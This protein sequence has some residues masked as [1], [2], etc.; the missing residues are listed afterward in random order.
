MTSR[1]VARRRTL[2]SRYP[3][4][5]GI[6]ARFLDMTKSTKTSY[7]A[8]RSLRPRS[9]SHHNPRYP[10]IY[11]SQV[12][13]WHHKAWCD[14]GL[15]AQRSYCS[16]LTWVSVVS[17]EL[18]THSYVLM[19]FSHVTAISLPV[20]LVFLGKLLLAPHTMHIISWGMLYF[21]W[22]CGPTEQ[23]LIWSQIDIARCNL[24]LFFKLLLLTFDTTISS[25]HLGKYMLFHIMHN[26]RMH[27]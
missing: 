8:S 4:I 21:G 6:I 15:T 12:V 10:N 7:E 5:P 14:R 20:P 11:P 27:I 2:I 26:Y 22:H 24:R 18:F 16:V 9:T 3:T 1:E 17:C 19:S 25:Y 23:S 13:V